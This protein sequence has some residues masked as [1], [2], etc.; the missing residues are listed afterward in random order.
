MEL[1]DVS[2][3][4]DIDCD[5]MDCYKGAGNKNSSVTL[6]YGFPKLVAGNNYI[7]IDEQSVSA[8]VD[9]IPRWWTV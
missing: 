8:S 1:D 7:G 6:P 5:V 3:D 2:E 9:I 4:I